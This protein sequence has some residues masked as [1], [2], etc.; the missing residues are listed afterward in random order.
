[1]PIFQVTGVKWCNRLLEQLGTMRL[2]QVSRIV[3]FGAAEALS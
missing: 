3:A 2:S 1:M